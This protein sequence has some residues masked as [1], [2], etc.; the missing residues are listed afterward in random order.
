MDVKPIIADINVM[1]I[2]G[3]ASGDL[4]GAALAEA[5]KK[6]SPYI[7]L[8]GIAGDN[9]TEAGV[10]PVFHIRDMAFLGFTEIIRHLPYI[11]RVRKKLLNMIAEKRIKT[12]ILID[13]P[14]FNLN[15]AKFAKRMGVKII[16]YISPQVWAWHQSRIKKSENLSIRYLLY[17]RSRK[18]Y[19]KKMV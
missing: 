3:E 17:F 11:R 16:Y 19:I 4:H 7:K 5:L 12:V 1:I 13:Y 15:F 18:K 2:A 10:D 14:G 9:M 6:K 8:F